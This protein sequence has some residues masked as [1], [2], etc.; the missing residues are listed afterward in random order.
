M[1]YPTYVRGKLHRHR[2]RFA[3]RQNSRPRGDGIRPADPKDNHTTQG[4]DQRV[5]VVALDSDLCH[6]RPSLERLLGADYSVCMGYTRGL[7]ALVTEETDPA[8]IRELSQRTPA[9]VVIGGFS[10]DARH[11]HEALVAAVNAGAAAYLI[12]PS[13]RL[14]AAHVR[15]DRE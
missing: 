10:V 12:E 3:S 6:L 15:L 5:R 9:V 1:P 8:V 4:I 13:V 11:D 7:H 2:G 14:I